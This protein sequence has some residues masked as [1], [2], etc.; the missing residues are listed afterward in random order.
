[1]E[2]IILNEMADVCCLSQD[3]I[4]SLK[5]EFTEKEI[6]LYLLVEYYGY[7]IEELLERN[8]GYTQKEMLE[9]LHKIYVFVRNDDSFGFLYNSLGWADS[10]RFRN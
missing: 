9:T 7:T 3:Y 5:T 1:M 6:L 10:T 4:D 8:F 2:Q